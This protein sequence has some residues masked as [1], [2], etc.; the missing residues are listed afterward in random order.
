MPNPIELKLLPE[1]AATSHTRT[2]SSA[3]RASQDRSIVDSA[4]E[5]LSTSRRI[6]KETADAVDGYKPTLVR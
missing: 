6:L 5:A 3:K 4:N 1:W 2:L